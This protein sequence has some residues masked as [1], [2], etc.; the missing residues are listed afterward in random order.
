M[1]ARVRAENIRKI[2]QWQG[3]LG[4]DNGVMHGLDSQ[5]RRDI[6]R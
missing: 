3:D 4:I 6:N 5:P 1:W 2:S